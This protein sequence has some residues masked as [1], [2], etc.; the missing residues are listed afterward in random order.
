MSK[1]T[2]FDF[3]FFPNVLDFLKDNNKKNDNFETEIVEVV[4]KNYYFL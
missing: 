1:N 3:H 4:V 2:L